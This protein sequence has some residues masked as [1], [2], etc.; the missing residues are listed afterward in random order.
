MSRQIVLSYFLCSLFFD[1]Y[2]G[3]IVFLNTL[4]RWLVGSKKHNIS[5]SYAAFK[6]LRRLFEAPSDMI[7]F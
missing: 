6:Y 2:L 5:D 3:T 7:T 4:Y 1:W